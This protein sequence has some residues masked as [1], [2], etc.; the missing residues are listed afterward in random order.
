MPSAPAG[1]GRPAK[2]SR[3]VRHASMDRA[4]GDHRRHDDGQLR[5]PDSHLRHHQGME[6][7]FLVASPRRVMTTA[8]PPRSRRQR[9]GRNGENREI[10]WGRAR[11]PQ[12]ADVREVPHRPFCAA[13]RR[14]ST[15]PA[16]P[17][18]AAAYGDDPIVLA[19]AEYRLGRPPPGPRPDRASVENTAPG[20]CASA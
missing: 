15:V 17:R 8:R 6:I 10:P 2:A 11:V 4:R 19:A 3:Q 7:T 20:A 1:V 9:V 14:R 12:V 18:D 16:S 13:M 5:D